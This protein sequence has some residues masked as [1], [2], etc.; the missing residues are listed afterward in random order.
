MV[1]DREFKIEQ[2]SEEGNL[3]EL[4]DVLGSDYSQEEIDLALSI[5]IAFA[6]IE[7]ANYLISLDAD[8]SWKNYEGA[9][10]AIHNDKMEGLQFAIS[11]GVD[12][13]VN[14]GMFLNASV[15][16]STNTQNIEIVEFLLSKGADINL[17]SKDMKNV[18]KGFGSNQLTKLL[19][20]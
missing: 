1:E 9:Y 18:A 10:Y 2:L 6:N 17:L 19:K 3:E 16:S 4:K 13:N 7:T 15:M 11:Q 20:V 5:A 12:V 14:E 8:I